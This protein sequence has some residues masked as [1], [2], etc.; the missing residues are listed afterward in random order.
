MTTQQRLTAERE[1]VLARVTN[2]EQEYRAKWTEIN[3]L[4]VAIAQ[5]NGGI[6]ADM[7]RY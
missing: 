2:T 7:E 3:R 5:A 1:K 4:T 6:T